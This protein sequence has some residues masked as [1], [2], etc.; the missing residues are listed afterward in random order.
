MRSWIGKGTAYPSV[1]IPFYSTEGPEISVCIRPNGGLS[2]ER[3]RACT[4]LSEA[5]KLVMIYGRATMDRHNR[6]AIRKLVRV[7]RSCSRYAMGTLEIRRVAQAYGTRPS[8][9]RG[10]MR[11]T[12]D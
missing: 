7:I 5:L 4:G 6:M 3:K 2:A 11:P 10:D 8:Y 9:F 12:R 1:R